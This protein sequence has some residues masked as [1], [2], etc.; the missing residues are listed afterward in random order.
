MKFQIIDHSVISYSFELKNDVELSKANP[1]EGKIIVGLS[2]PNEIIENDPVSIVLK[3]ELHSPAYDL[4]LKLA[5]QIENKGF[6]VDEIKNKEKD[7]LAVIYPYAIS[8]IKNL[9]MIAD[10]S[11]N[12]LPYLPVKI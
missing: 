1:Q 2:I 5:F 6:S 11:G 7:I 4:E 3:I 10:I 12:G 9:L 8:S